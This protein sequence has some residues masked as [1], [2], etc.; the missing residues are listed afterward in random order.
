MIRQ[1]T[2]AGSKHAQMLLTPGAGGA[3]FQ[4]RT[5]TNGASGS[6]AAANATVPLWLRI[7]RTLTGTTS[8]LIGKISTD[9]V[10]WT[11]IGSINISN[12]GGTVLM[13]MALTSHNNAL[14]N[15]T[16]FDNVSSSVTGAV[17]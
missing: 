12:M 1:T 3:Y 15:T 14:L 17:T 6:S 10:N 16:T 7:E 8:T 4:Y 5:S 11:T 13:G 2:N 9:G